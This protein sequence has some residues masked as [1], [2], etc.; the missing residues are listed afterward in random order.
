[1]TGATFVIFFTKVVI[2]PR[3]AIHAPAVL[4]IRV[5]GPNGIMVAQKFCD[6]F[7]WKKDIRYQYINSFQVN[8]FFYQ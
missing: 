7:S 6:I 1:M 8:C 3:W 5:T 2:I 4:E